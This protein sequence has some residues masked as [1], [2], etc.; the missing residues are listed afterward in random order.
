[1]N[2]INP[3]IKFKTLGGNE[4][5]VAVNDIAAVNEG[6]N[7]HDRR[8]AVNIWVRGTGEEPFVVDHK[9]K[10]VIEMISQAQAEQMEPVEA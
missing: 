8:E 9:T 1:M 10:E 7:E 4:F 3:L 2:R 5:L 6:Y